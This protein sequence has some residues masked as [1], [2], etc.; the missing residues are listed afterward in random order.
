MIACSLS[1]RL[2]ARH[3]RSLVARCS[4]LS[5]N[6]ASVVS[7][8][9]ENQYVL[10]T[11]L[12]FSLD[13]YPFLVPPP[14][15]RCLRWW[16]DLDYGM[17]RSSRVSSVFHVIL[18]YRRHSRALQACTEPKPCSETPRISRGSRSQR[19]LYQGSVWRTRSQIRN[20]YPQVGESLRPR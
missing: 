12:M 4:V 2:A 1:A 5:S 10:E 8:S 20:C 13:Q 18:V 3:T 19:E 7:R 16:K 15:T 17:Y 11:E 6:S 14:H 9:A